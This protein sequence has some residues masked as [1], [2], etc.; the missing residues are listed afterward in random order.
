MKTIKRFTKRIEIVNRLFFRVHYTLDCFWF[1]VQFKHGFNYWQFLL[2]GISLF[3]YLLLVFSSFYSVVA[4]SNSKILLQVVEGSIQ[5]QSWE[6]VSN[7]QVTVDILIQNPPSTKC[8]KTCNSNT[9]IKDDISLFLFWIKSSRCFFHKTC[10]HIIYYN[11]ERKKFSVSEKDLHFQLYIGMF[12][13]VVNAKIRPY[14]K[15]D[16][17]IVESTNSKKM[18]QK[19]NV[20][21]SMIQ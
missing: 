3:L 16:P 8:Y 13:T 1:C 21:L 4:F 10:S 11:E 2:V 6:P 5:S 12:A 18:E 19:N 9:D 14:R 17:C 15:L 7:R 20:K